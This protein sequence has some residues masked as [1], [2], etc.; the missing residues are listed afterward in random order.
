MSFI[1][2]LALVVMLGVIAFGADQGCRDREGCR[3]RRCPSGE[4]AVLVRGEWRM[5]CVC[6]P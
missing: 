6:T 2:A 4:R 5:Q 3:A 1:E